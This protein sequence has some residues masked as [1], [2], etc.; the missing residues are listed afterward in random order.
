MQDN[1]L[2][3]TFVKF[4]RNQTVL[5]VVNGF[6]KLVFPQTIGAIDGTHI[7]IIAPSENSSDFYNRK[8]YYSIIMQA[9]ADP[10][11]G[12]ESE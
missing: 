8:G 5:D 4:P 9:V 11:K 3:K 2:I 12:V 1:V 6:A 7:P 10:G